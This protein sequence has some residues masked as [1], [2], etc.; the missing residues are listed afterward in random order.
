MKPSPIWS[1]TDDGT[2]RIVLYEL[3]SA[4]HEFYGDHAPVIVIYG[5]QA[6]HE[7]NPESDIDVLLLYDKTVQPGVEISRLSA[8]LTELNLRYQV[9]ISVLPMYDR[10]YL[11]S[12]SAF[13][14]NVR[15]EGILIESV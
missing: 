13:L 9:L 4:L 12:N 14:K 3:K 1:P 8:I 10:E 2:V 5:S 15:R 6:R 11:E 7:A